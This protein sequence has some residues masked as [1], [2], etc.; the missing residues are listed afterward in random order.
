MWDITKALRSVGILTRDGYFEEIGVRI[1]GHADKIAWQ[2]RTDQPRSDPPAKIA[3]QQRIHVHQSSVK[4]LSVISVNSHL[5]YLITGG[6]DNAVALSRFVVKDDKSV[7]CNTWIIPRAHAGSVTAV[8]RL[9]FSRAC[10]VP[11]PDTDVGSECP[12]GAQLH[13]YRFATIGADQKLSIWHL[14]ISPDHKD[15]LLP[16]LREHANFETSVADVSGMDVMEYLPGGPGLVL[17][18]VGHE[19][20]R[21]R[22]LTEESENNCPYRSMN[23]DCVCATKRILHRDRLQSE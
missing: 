1:A 9:P 18:G 21:V 7:L 10:C 4:C 11:G 12:N 3:W 15:D 13:R 23:K 20:W 14:T 19:R 5:A 6:D 8:A 17:C 2:H 22:D 16:C